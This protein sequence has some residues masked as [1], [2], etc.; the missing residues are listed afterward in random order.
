MRKIFVLGLVVAFALAVSGIAMAASTA[1][2]TVTYQVSTINEIAVSGDPG[3]LII[4]SAVSG[5]GSAPAEA[6]D[7]STTYALTTNGT[8]ETISAGLDSDMPSGVTL[9]INLAAPTGGSSDGDVSLSSTAAE[10]VNSISGVAQSGLGITYKL[11][12]TMAAA[13][14]ASAATKTVT[15]TLAAP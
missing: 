2:Q 4:N 7:A 15:L 8:G 13:V 9:S 11:D 1:T 3:S 10:V 12:A 14:M 6:T 5:A